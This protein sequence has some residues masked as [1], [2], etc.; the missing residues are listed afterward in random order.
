MVWNAGVRVGRSTNTGIRVSNRGTISVS[1]GGGKSVNQSALTLMCQPPQISK[2]H[3]YV[4]FFIGITFW[5]PI[6][7][8]IF[9]VFTMDSSIIVKILKSLLCVVLSVG[10]GYAMYFYY[11]KVEAKNRAIL[12]SYTRQW[13]CLKCG[14]EFE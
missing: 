8:G 11:Q 9:N 13:I 3:K 4:L 6:T 7:L 10:I 12:E 1:T 5:L 14:C 2:I